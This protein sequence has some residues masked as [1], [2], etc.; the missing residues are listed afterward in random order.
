MREVVS[1][2]CLSYQVFPNTGEVHLLF[3]GYAHDIFY[4]IQVT[5]GNPGFQPVGGNASV[6][7]QHVVHVDLLKPFFCFLLESSWAWSKICVLVSEDLITDLSGHQYLDVGVFGNPFADQE[8]AHGGPDGGDIIGLY[9]IYQGAQRIEDVLFGKKHLG[10]IGSKMIRND[11]G[12]F[13]INGVD[14]YPHG[15]GPDGFVHGSRGNGAYQA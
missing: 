7:S 11:T 5:K 4:E 2:K 13:G 15:K 6:G 14:I 9:I 10:M 12:I 1:L 8:H 3:R